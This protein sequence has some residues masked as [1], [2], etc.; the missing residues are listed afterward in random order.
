MSAVKLVNLRG[1]VLGVV[2]FPTEWDAAF[3]EGGVRIYLP[4]DPPIMWS[5]DAAMN[6]VSLRVGALVAAYT[7]RG[8]H[9]VRLVGCSIEEFEK[10]DG[11][12]FSPSAY[13]LRTV[14]G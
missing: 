8:G 4:P 6:A 2:S 13:Y 9:A 3:R 5:P 7:E 12:S 10:K 14:T 11:C 1:D